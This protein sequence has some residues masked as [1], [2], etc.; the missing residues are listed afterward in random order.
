MQ[1]K[2]IQPNVALACILCAAISGPSLAQQIDVAK[3]S[4]CDIPIS[5]SGTSSNW[6]TDEAG[7]FTA[8]FTGP[9]GVSQTVPGFWNGDN[10]F[11]LRFTPT[12]EGAWS[13]TTTSTNPQLNNLT[14]SLNAQ[15]AAPTSHGF[16]RVDPQYKNSFV[17][18]DGTRYFM[19]GQT[20]Y[21]WLN[22]AM[23]NDNWKTSVDSMLAVWVHQSSLQRLCEQRSG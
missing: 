10:N 23:A 3:W 9:G 20:Y 19:M 22:G 11:V 13:Y 4:T 21:D 17:W 5:V 7:K 12:V 6:Y 8:T 18:D 1:Y 2:S 14:G 15:P 16:L